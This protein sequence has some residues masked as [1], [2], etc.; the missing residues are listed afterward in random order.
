ML[1]DEA[2][3]RSMHLRALWLRP[4]GSVLV[5]EALAKILPRRDGLW[6]QPPE[7]PARLSLRGH[8]EPVGHDTPIASG[9]PNI[10]C[11]A[12]QELDRIGV[13]IITCTDVWPEA[14]RPSRMTKGPGERR[15]APEA[16]VVDLWLVNLPNVLKGIE[17]LTTS[18]A[19]ILIDNTEAKTHETID[20]HVE[21]DLE[22]TP[23][24][25]TWCAKCRWI[26]CCKNTGYHMM[27]RKIRTQGLY[28]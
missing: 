13:S 9:R 12:L 28:A 26:S 7:P 8:R 1:G 6:G 14:R 24:P 19:T 5:E 3:E 4:Q 21:A 11:I 23:Q 22:N 18:L 17:D 15:E 27:D 2:I 25:P 20:T 16:D 10:G